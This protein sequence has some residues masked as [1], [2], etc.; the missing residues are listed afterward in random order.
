MRIQ[1]GLLALYAACTFT[2]SAFAETRIE[3]P[4]DGFKTRDERASFAKALLSYFEKLDS[5]IPNL[6]P[7]EEDWYK[8]ERERINVI[9]DVMLSP[10]E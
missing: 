7:R 8:E 4:V 1:W 3:G 2:C 9:R 5:Q 6:H 10:G